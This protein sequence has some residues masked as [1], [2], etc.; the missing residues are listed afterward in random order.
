MVMICHLSILTS[1]NSMF[2]S[3]KLCSWFKTEREETQH[4]QTAFSFHS[5]QCIWET[6]LFSLITLSATTQKVMTFKCPSGNCS[7]WARSAYSE[8]GER[9]R[10][11]TSTEL[12][13]RSCI[14]TGFFKC[15]CHPVSQ[16]SIANHQSHRPHP[17]QVLTPTPTTCFCIT[18]AIRL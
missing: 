5:C 2:S 9:G 18:F 15:W 10:D 6:V 12:V 11:E 3:T 17:N 4:C 16:R 8:T 7:T 1:Y 14:L 13:P